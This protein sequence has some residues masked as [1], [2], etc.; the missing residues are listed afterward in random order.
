MHRRRLLL[1]D[2]RRLFFYLLPDRE[3]VSFVQRFY[4]GHDF[5]W[6]TVQVSLALDVFVLLGLLLIDFV[7]DCDYR[8]VLGV[9]VEGK[10]AEDVALCRFLFNECCEVFKVYLDLVVAK[11]KNDRGLS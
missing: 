8:A 4:S 5:N 6:Q 7:K 9:V 3:L 1:L 11:I 10:D 2:K